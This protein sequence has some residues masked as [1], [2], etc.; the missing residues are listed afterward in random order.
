MDKV[1]WNGHTLVETFEQVSIL[2]EHKPMTAIVDKGYQGV[3]VE[4]VQILHSGQGRGVTRTMKA[5]IKRRSAI[6]PTTAG[7]LKSDGRLA[8]NPPKGT[9]GG[10]LHAVMCGAGHNSRL[11][12]KKLR[13]FCALLGIDLPA[14]LDALL[15]LQRSQRLAV[16]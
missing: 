2:A 12:L 5:M 15:G 3:Q 14:M 16:A 8:R 1:P 10:A 6:E 9:L 7:H 13:L 4:G 11:L